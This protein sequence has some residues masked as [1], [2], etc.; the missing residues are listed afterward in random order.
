[1]LRLLLPR[2]VGQAAFQVNFIVVFA[3][4]SSL[5]DAHIAALNFAWQLLMLPHGVVALSIST[6][7]FPTMARLYKQGRLEDLS[8]TF[9]RALRPLIFLS[10]PAAVGL[11]FYRTAIVQT[12]FQAGAFSSASTDLVASALA[13]FAVGLVS[14]GGR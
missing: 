2:I 12:L 11:F 6:V 4:A 1:M 9:R 14:Y 8:A 3:F 13:L 5:G 10:L 7:I